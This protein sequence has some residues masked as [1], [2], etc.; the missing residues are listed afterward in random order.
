M[1]HQNVLHYNKKHSEA[2][3]QTTVTTYVTSKQL[4]LFAVAVQHWDSAVSVEARQHYTNTETNSGAG[5]DH[6]S[7]VTMAHWTV[8][9][10]PTRPPPRE[11]NHPPAAIISDT[12]YLHTDHDYYYIW[13]IPN[14]YTDHDYYYIWIIPNFLYV[15]NG[16]GGVPIWWSARL[17]RQSSGHA[18]VRMGGQRVHL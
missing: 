2:Q 12:I 10:Q 15:N 5:S 9:R 7:A 6:D 17:P 16:E 13:I 14:F 3:S 1:S 11:S 8:R 18:C 4:L